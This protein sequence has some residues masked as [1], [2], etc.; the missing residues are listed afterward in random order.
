MQLG[1][2]APAHHPGQTGTVTSVN[3][4]RPTQFTLRGKLHQTGI[5][6]V[7][8]S[9]A[10][11]I[12]ELGLK[13]DVQADT[14]VH[15]GELKAV[16]GYPQED[17]RW[18][19]E[20]LAE[21]LEP[22]RF[23]ENLTTAGLSAS[24]AVI[25]ERWRVGSAVLEVT[26]PRDPCWKLGVRMGDPDFPRRFREAA[27]PGAYFSVHTAGSVAAGDAIEVVHLPA[28]PITVGLIARLRTEDSELSRLL[29]QL[30]RQDLSPAEWQEVLSSAQG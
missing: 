19:S 16:Y 2:P 8:A 17:Y 11:E 7:P 30:C 23:G 14:K 1:E 25:G 5:C 6:K 27:R 12:A 28:H 20:Q 18:W 21:Q 29:L 9:G 3:L 4:A 15:G 24:G 22:G 26:Q 13:G 10:V